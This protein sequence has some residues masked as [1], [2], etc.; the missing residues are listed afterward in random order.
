[1][2]AVVRVPELVLY[3]VSHAFD[4]RRDRLRPWWRT[5]RRALCPAIPWDVSIRTRAA[6]TCSLSIRPTPTGTTSELPF[7]CGAHTSIV[8]RMNSA[9]R[10]IQLR[11]NGDR[12]LPTGRGR[13][14]VALRCPWSCPWPGLRPATSICC[15]PTTHVRSMPDSRRRGGVLPYPETTGAASF[16]LSSAEW[17]LVGGVA[18]S[19]RRVGRC[20]SAEGSAAVPCRCRL[21]HRVGSAVGRHHARGSW[22]HSATEPE[23]PSKI[24]WR[25]VEHFDGVSVRH[26]CLSWSIELSVDALVACEGAHATEP[27]ARSSST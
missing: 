4:S 11:P 10:R 23:W 2:C 27:A 6:V 18:R 17:S 22:F 9:R 13:D 15:V 12:H 3:A 26:A 20:F 8:W 1:M 5:A 21:L 7:R 14:I 25:I 16:R 24:F 19:A